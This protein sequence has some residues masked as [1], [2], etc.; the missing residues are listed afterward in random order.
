[1]PSAFNDSFADPDNAIFCLNMDG[2]MLAISF[3]DGG[4]YVMD[5]EHPE[6]DL[7]VYE[8]SDYTEFAGGFHGD[9]FAFSA[10]KSGHSI[11]GLINVDAVSYTHLVRKH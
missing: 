3:S 2:T 5:T 1:M 6:D 11:F 8:S 4:L 10:G 7:I 9:K